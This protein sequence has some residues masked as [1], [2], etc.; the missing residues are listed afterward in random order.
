[1]EMSKVIKELEGVFDAINKEF[2]NNE[3]KRPVITVQSGRRSVLGWCSSR[4][5]WN[6]DGTKVYEVNIVAE[7][8]GRS[9]EEIIETM[10]HECVHLY[11]GQRGV[12]DCGPTQ[13]HNKNFKEVAESHGLTVSRMK[14]RGFACTKL[15]EVGKKF[16]SKQKLSFDGSR[17]SSEKISTYEKPVTYI[18][19][20]CGRKIRFHNY[21]LNVIC[22]DCNKKFEPI[23][24]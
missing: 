5:R 18:C 23:L 14:N 10:L 12:S 20:G 11:N 24:N 1:M 16:A 15:N 9:K 19:S 2:Y 6:A 13:Y 8:L 17:I 7:N 21:K 4:E 3:M 22:G